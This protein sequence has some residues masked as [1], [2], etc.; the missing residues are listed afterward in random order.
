VAAGSGIVP[1]GAAAMDISIPTTSPSR[2]QLNALAETRAY[3]LALRL[4]LAVFYIYVLIAKAPAMVH[5]MLSLPALGFPILPVAQVLARL[6]FLLFITLIVGM[7]LLRRRPVAKTQGLAGRLVA[8]GGSCLPMLLPLLPHSAPSVTMLLISA[9]LAML[10]NILSLWTLTYLGRSFSVMP[11]AFEQLAL[12]GV[13]LQF[14]SVYALVVLVAQLALQLGRM[15]YEER[16]LAAAFPDYV[17]YQA[18]TARL[19]PGVY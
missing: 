17:A 6:A 13:V 18:R 3:D 7:T 16:V 1:E 4:P 19:I 14:F 15:H 10:G 5:T 11:E 8:L 9:A 2:R 12:A